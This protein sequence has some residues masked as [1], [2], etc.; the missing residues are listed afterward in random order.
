MF[1]QLQRGGCKLRADTV[2]CKTCDGQLAGAFQDDGSMLLCANHLRTQAHAS[3]TLVHESIHAFD[4][5][6][7]KVNWSDC[8]HHACSEIRAATLSGD[9]NFA[10]EF[11]LR[12]N[13]SIAKQFQN[14][15]RRRAELSV[16]RN[17]YCDALAVRLYHS[18]TL[19]LPMT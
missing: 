11:F 4:S 5:C 9:C 10:R 15:V 19:S 13:F 12:R 7:A 16:N 17:P 3:N 2:M 1:E 6:R 8:T 18:V 14:C